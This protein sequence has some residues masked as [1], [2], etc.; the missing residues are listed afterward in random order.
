MATSSLFA[1]HRALIIEH[2]FQILCPSQIS[3]QDIAKVIIEFGNKYEGFIA[4]LNSKEFEISED[5]LRMNFSG[6]AN[7]ISMQRRNT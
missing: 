3:I 5:L 7:C 6:T 2:W 4:W 1:E